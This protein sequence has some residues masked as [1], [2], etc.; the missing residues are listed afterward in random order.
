MW[1]K[2]FLVV[3]LIEECVIEVVVEV[4]KLNIDRRVIVG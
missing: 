3:G 4:V 1:G 2:L